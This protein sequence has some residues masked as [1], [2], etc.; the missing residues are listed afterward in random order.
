MFTFPAFNKSYNARKRSYKC[1]RKCRNKR[2]R[3]LIKSSD[4]DVYGCDNCKLAGLLCDLITHPQDESNLNT[5]QSPVIR[6]GTPINALTRFP[7]RISS[8]SI[9]TTQMLPI[10]SQPQHLAQTFGAASIRSMPQPIINYPMPHYN[11]YPQ[12]VMNMPAPLYPSTPLHPR[13]DYQYLK[14]TYR[15]N[16]GVGPEFPEQL[17]PESFQ[18]LMS[19]DAFSLSSPH[20]SSGIS[21][22]ITKAMEIE[23]LK[24]FFFKLNSIFP[25]VDEQT[26]W[27]QYYSDN[28][29]T[30]VIYAMVLV[31]SR[32]RWSQDIL[33]PIFNNHSPYPDAFNRFVYDLELK[34]R[35]LLLLIPEIADGDTLTRLLVHTLLSMNFG[36]TNSSHQQ[37]SQDLAAAITCGYS[38]CLH[39]KFTYDNLIATSNTLKASYLQKLWWLLYILDVFNAVINT[40]TLLIK[41]EDFDLSQVTDKEAKILI[42]KATRL[43]STFQAIYNNDKLLLA[44]YEMELKQDIITPFHDHPFN[45][46]KFS[47]INPQKYHETLSTVKAIVHQF[48]NDLIDYLCLIMIYGASDRINNKHY[49]INPEIIDINKKAIRLFTVIDKSLLIQMHITSSSFSLFLSILFKY[50]IKI[51]YLEKMPQ[52]PIRSDI[53]DSIKAQVN[54]VFDELW[55]TTEFFR[56]WWFIQNTESHI[57]TF[58]TKLELN[59]NNHVS[60]IVTSRPMSISNLITHHQISRSESGHLHDL[61][62]FNDPKHQSAANT[63]GI[64]AVHDKYP[65]S[66][67]SHPMVNPVNNKLLTLISRNLFIDNISHFI[68]QDPHLK[69]FFV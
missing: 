19:I 22:I 2:V 37:L 65:S 33:S 14:E 28:I 36:V 27:S 35:L 50:K 59:N 7:G 5:T 43:K 62:G 20:S 67:G 8:P 64:T 45:V 49:E 63:A 44:Q 47:D 66:S 21:K 57:N 41:Q 32:D 29:D 16:I 56:T 42:T 54:Q 60:T 17:R 48:F 25:V 30:I 34:I 26:F 9:Q 3:C 51:T 10:S 11:F 24:V 6:Q 46:S 4:Y 40:N 39:R 52:P 15:F 61:T 55:I 23:L 12:S 38:M 58:L 68:T 1:C 18:Y 13:I 31:V 53:N 69:H